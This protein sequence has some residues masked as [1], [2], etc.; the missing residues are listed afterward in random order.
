MITIT[1]DYPRRTSVN[2]DNDLGR[3]LLMPAVI[4]IVGDFGSAISYQGDNKNISI[5]PPLPSSKINKLGEK[6]VELATSIDDSAPVVYA[7]NKIQQH[8]DVVDKSLLPSARPIEDD[9]S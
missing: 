5:V 1:D 4:D 6:L 7:V 2:A 3:F 8:V 9:L